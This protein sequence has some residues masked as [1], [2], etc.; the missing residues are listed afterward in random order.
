V[1]AATIAIATVRN[2]VQQPTTLTEVIFCCFSRGDLLIYQR[3][4]QP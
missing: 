3:L 4:L 2:F 1:Q